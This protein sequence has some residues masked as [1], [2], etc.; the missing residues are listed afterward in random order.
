LHL[1]ELIKRESGAVLRKVNKHCLGE[2]LKVVL[3]AV[4]H[5][6]VNVDNKLVELVETL[7][8]VVKEAFNV[9][10]GPSER[11]DTGAKTALEII[12]VRGKERSGIWSNFVHN[13]NALTNNVL[14]LVV[15][16]LELVLLEKHDLG[17][18]RNLNANTS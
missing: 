4:L 12:D 7:V 5:D 16:V 17:R 1:D 3:N 8:N 18:L 6:V 10:R 11:A 9:H 15:V 13:T 14:K 2:S